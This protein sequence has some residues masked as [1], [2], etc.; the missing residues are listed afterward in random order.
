MSDE[1]W[2][3]PDAAD[4]TQQDS[5]FPG[6]GRHVDDAEREAALEAEPAGNAEVGDTVDTDEVDSGAHDD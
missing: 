1:Q 4:G 5:A 3:D 6:A 2:S